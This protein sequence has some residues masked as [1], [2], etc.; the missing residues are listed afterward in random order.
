MKMRNRIT[1]IKMLQA[2]ILQDYLRRAFAETFAD[3]TW[4]SILYDEVQKGVKS[5]YSR[6]YIGAWD[7]MHLLGMDHY[8]IDDMDTTII[9]TILKGP[10]GGPFGR[11]KFKKINQY[12]DNL[13]EDRNIDAHA[14][15]NEGD[16]ELLQWAYISLSN[17][18]RFLSA[19]A[20]ASDC[21]VSDEN[22]ISFARKYQ[23]EIASLRSQF[24]DDYKE[25][26]IIAAEEEN[27]IRDIERIKSSIKPFNTYVELSRQYLNRRDNEGKIDLLLY[28]K[29]LEIAADAGIV[30]ACARV[31][32]MFFTGLLTDVD[33]IKAAEYYEKGFSHL[34]PSQKL[35]LA[36]IYLNNLSNTTHSKEEAMAIIKSCVSPRWEIITYTSKEG[37]EFYTVK[38]IKR[39]S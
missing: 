34:E 7:K 24:E 21:V 15:G 28:K 31:G 38:R 10:T 3:D 32:D 1:D 2:H 29:F 5:D 20:K 37:Y 17:M 4:K 33:Y 27:I 14:T 8:S 36:S 18:S 25:A 12:L 22:R 23:T 6:S 30:F 16:S 13:Q 26:L 35:S 9:S 19:V 39:N 11:C